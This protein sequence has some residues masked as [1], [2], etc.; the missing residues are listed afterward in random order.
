MKLILFVLNDA[1]KTLEVLESWKEAGAGGATVLFSTGMGR[2]KLANALRD[3]LPLI[4]S[5]SD[6][7]TQDENLS[8]TIFTVLEDSLV[9]KIIQATVKIVGDLD[10]P[11]NGILVVL[12]AETVHGL[13]NY[14]KQNLA[15]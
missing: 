12:P 1:E 8:R 10:E 6:F 4:P 11:G 7:Y 15:K 3:D 5:L 14:P 9:E 13:I 2:I